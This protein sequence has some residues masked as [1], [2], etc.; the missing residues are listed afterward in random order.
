MCLACRGKEHQTTIQPA[1]YH[2]QQTFDPSTEVISYLD[3]LNVQKIYIKVFDIDCPRES[4]IAQP[5]SQL[6]FLSGHPFKTQFIPVIFITNRTFLKTS[7]LE[8]PSLVRKTNSLL[9]TI[10]SQAGI[11]FNEIQL[12]CD[13]SQSTQQKF[14]QFCISL[15]NLLPKSIKISSTIRLHQ[16][17]YPDMTG[18]PPVDKG[19][20][21]AYNTG[22]IG[23]WEEKN[24]IFNLEE[25]LKYIQNTRPYPLTLDLAL[26]VF[27]W[28]L[29]FR[30]EELVHI[31]HKPDASIK[32]NDL[33]FRKLSE[34]RFELQKDQILNGLY[35]YAGDLLK[36]EKPTF[37]ELEEFC[38]DWYGADVQ[39]QGL[40]SLR[41][42]NLILYHL[43]N[44]LPQQLPTYKIHQLID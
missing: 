24:S 23:S 14:F 29:V 11:D 44:D 30:D 32:K 37:A 10:T 35:L 2:W 28:A 41:S 42:K 5:L 1:F 7:E 20:L 43:H 31:I 9:Q 19:V 17:K 21:M 38:E 12:D 16:F 39:N 18:I 6:Q 3:S 8:I 34:N 25:S 15:N 36:I 33:V 13:W 4:S 40:T 26:P 22:K 27:Y